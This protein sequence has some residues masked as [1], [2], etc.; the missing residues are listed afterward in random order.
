[1]KEDTYELKVKYILLF[2]L[3]ACIKRANISDDLNNVA[4]LLVS[5]VSIL[6]NTIWTDAMAFDSFHD[7]QNE[8]DRKKHDVEVLW[9]QVMA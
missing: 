3:T 6:P 5:A 2:E 7:K 1:M 9:Q 4:W 8:N